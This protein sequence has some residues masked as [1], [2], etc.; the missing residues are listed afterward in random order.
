MKFKIIDKGTAFVIDNVKY[1]AMTDY[2][3]QFPFKANKIL[4]KTVLTNDFMVHIDE[5]QKH[6]KDT[7]LQSK[8]F[9]D[10]GDNILGLLALIFV[11]ENEVLNDKNYKEK[12]EL[13]EQL[14]MQALTQTG[15]AI[16][17]FF[18]SIKK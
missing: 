16:K 12:L 13:F 14:P 4:Y 7:E 8:L 3:T 6:P 1:E 15:E 18:G 17:N 9:M 2:E 5:M 10:Y 11:K